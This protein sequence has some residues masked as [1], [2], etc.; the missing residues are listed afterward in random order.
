[1]ASHG[2]VLHVAGI[3]T[4]LELRFDEGR[5]KQVLVNRIQNA[6]EAAGP[7]GDVWVAVRRQAQMVWIEDSGPGDPRGVDPC[8]S[9]S[10]AACCSLRAPPKSAPRSWLSSRV[11]GL[12]LGRVG[13]KG[14]GQEVPR[15]RAPRIAPIGVMATGVLV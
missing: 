1:M 14:R 15:T 3:D 6:T 7:G 2:M 12:L 11:P 10:T 8:I 9:R 5:I 13:S 4:P